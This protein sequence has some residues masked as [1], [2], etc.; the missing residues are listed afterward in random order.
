MYA[1]HNDDKEISHL[2]TTKGFL[3]CTWVIFT[4]CF[5]PKGPSSDYTNIKITQK[6]YW[7]MSGPY[8]NETPFLQW[9]LPYI[10][11]LPIITSITIVKNQESVQ[12]TRTRRKIFSHS[13]S[14]KSN[15]KNTHLSYFQ[16]KPINCKKWD[17][18]ITN[19]NSSFCCVVNKNC[20][21]VSYY[22]SGSGN[23]PEERSSY[24]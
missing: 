14:K 16:Y 9:I 19:A 1:E 2:I 18:I 4:A 20:V 15:I 8:R 11:H 12:N 13:L 3:L 17:L 6:S 24:L 23:N 10:L 7:V 22:A 21:P 5:G